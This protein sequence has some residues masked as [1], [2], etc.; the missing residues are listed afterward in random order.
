MFQHYSVHIHFQYYN[1]RIE[2][3]MNHTLKYIVTMQIRNILDIICYDIRLR[4]SGG[5]ICLIFLNVV[6]KSTHERSDA[7]SLYIMNYLKC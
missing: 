3:V 2:L 4:I 1:N 5:I 7:N 6:N